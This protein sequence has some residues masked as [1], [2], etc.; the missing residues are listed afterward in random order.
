MDG[1]C[2]G[3]G[4][5]GPSHPSAVSLCRPL[6][7]WQGG[8]VKLLSARNEMSGGIHLVA[9]HYQPVARAEYPPDEARAERKE[10]ENGDDAGLRADNGRTAKPPAENTQQK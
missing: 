10:A 7:G 5:G 4:T 3:A 6:A 2:Y 1:T 9:S 8:S